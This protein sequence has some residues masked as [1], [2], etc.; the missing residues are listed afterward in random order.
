MK[1]Q[2]AE[3]K[4]PDFI[5]SPISDLWYVAQPFLAVSVR[6]TS[7]PRLSS[8]TPPVLL[9]LAARTNKR[10]HLMDGKTLSTNFIIWTESD[11]SVMTVAAAAAAAGYLSVFSP[12]AFADWCLKQC[13]RNRRT[14]KALHDPSNNWK[15]E[16]LPCYITLFWSLGWWNGVN[17]MFCQC[18][19][20]YVGGEGDKIGQTQFMLNEHLIYIQISSPIAFFH[21]GISYLL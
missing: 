16:L 13:K 7:P 12:L 20:R 1:F 10:S 11:G 21:P 9:F 18:G 17:M 2:G 4:K 3:R 5:L 14:R 8:A 19:S 15:N 6:D